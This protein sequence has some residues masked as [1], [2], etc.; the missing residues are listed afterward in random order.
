MRKRGRRYHARDIPIV[1][2]ERE[3]AGSIFFMSPIPDTYLFVL[4]RKI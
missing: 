1:K 2:G 4:T 3:I